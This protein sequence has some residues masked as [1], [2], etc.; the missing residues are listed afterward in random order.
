MATWLDPKGK[1][2]IHMLRACLNAPNNTLLFVDICIYGK[3]LKISG[4]SIPTNGGGEKNS[5]GRGQGGLSMYL[6]YII[7]ITCY[8]FRLLKIWQS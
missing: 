7:L 1:M 2:N 8:Y 6:Y 4:G 3:S 5:A